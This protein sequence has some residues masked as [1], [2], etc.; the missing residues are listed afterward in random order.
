M[1][2]VEGRDGFEKNPEESLGS[3]AAGA[4][5]TGEDTPMTPDNAALFAV[6][7]LLLPMFYFLLAAPAFLLVRLDVLP[8]ARLL[9]GMFNGYLLTLSVAGAIGTIAVALTGHLG[10]TI[11]IGLFT[12]FAVLS[13]RWYLQRMDFPS[14]V[15]PVDL[16]VARRLRRLHWGGMASNAVQVAGVVAC[17]PYIAVIPT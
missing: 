7:I 11:G 8:V 12:A 2:W 13:R 6:I 17:I 15:D 16:D 5:E 9:R 10:L 4:N 3:H 1:V 14:D